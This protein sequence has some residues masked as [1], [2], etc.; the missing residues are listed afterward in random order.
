[1]PPSSPGSEYALTRGQDACEHAS[2]S[3][4]FVDR[5]R[6]YLADGFVADGGE[7]SQELSME[8]KVG[9]EQ[10]WVSKKPIEPCGASARILS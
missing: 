6:H 2:S 8:E 4:G 7:L 5:G 9:P 3:L 10:S 1:M